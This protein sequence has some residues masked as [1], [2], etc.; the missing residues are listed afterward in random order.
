MS[1]RVDLEDGGIAIVE[2]LYR[3]N[4]LVLVGG[5]RNPRFPPNK[6]ILYDHKTDQYVA[7]LEFRSSVKAVKLSKDRLVVVLLTKIFVYTI[8]T[9][10]EKMFTFETDDNENG[11][12]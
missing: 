4:L 2:M 11:T 8:G 3:S 1:K 9:S 5:G 12:F 10:P 6:V 7:E